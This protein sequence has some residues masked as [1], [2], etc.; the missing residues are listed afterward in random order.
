MDSLAA[1]FLAAIQRYLHEAIDIFGHVSCFIVPSVFALQKFTEAGFKYA[2][3]IEYIPHFVDCERISAD[4]S[5]ETTRGVVFVGRLIAQKGLWTLLKAAALIP[6][7]PI[8]ILGDGDL[9]PALEKEVARQSIMNVNFRGWQAQSEVLETLRRARALVMPSECYETT[10]ISILEAGVLG[11]A[12]IVSNDTAMAEVVQDGKSG[13]VFP[14]GDSN[15]LAMCIKQLC[16]DVSLAERLGRG[17]RTRVEQVYSAEAHYH[18]ISK[19]Y[20]KVIEES[21]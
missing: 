8:T 13:L 16:S 11:R 17:A 6:E 2:D 21:R 18:Q 15:A 12:A 9:R 4:W 20:E 19:L 1:S 3:R 10:G 5:F 7:V 14:M